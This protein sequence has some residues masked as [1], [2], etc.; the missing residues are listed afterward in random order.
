MAGLDEQGAELGSQ[1][2]FTWAGTHQPGARARRI[3]EPEVW[4]QLQELGTNVETRKTV[5]PLDS[6]GFGDTELQV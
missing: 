4:V 2:K 1:V 5:S 6:K 3:A